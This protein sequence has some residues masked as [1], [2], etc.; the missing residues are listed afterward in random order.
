MNRVYGAI[1]FALLLFFTLFLTAWYYSL[2][3]KQERIHLQPSK[4]NEI[5]LNEMDE[6]SDLTNIHQPFRPREYIRI[7]RSEKEI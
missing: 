1:T 4:Q 7:Y 3:M 5:K 6:D 2:Q